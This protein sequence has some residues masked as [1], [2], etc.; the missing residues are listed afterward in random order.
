MQTVVHAVCSSQCTCICLGYR[1]CPHGHLYGQSLTPCYL[2]WVGD[3]RRPSTVACGTVPASATAVRATSAVG[4]PSRPRYQRGV[5]RCGGGIGDTTRCAG[6]WT[7]SRRS[8]C[9][10]GHHDDRG[11]NRVG[12][13]SHE[14]HTSRR[15]RAGRLVIPYRA[16]P[17]DHVS[18][19]AAESENITPS[20]RLKLRRKMQG[21]L[22]Q[23]H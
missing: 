5:A 18:L 20:H 9:A 4:S 23:L 16:E 14:P 12:P 19:A 3:R 21:M 2:G 6:R 15:P 1:S 10:P 22:L 11:S 13:F 7:P 17:H 8:P